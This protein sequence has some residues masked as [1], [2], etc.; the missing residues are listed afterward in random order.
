MEPK[1]QDLYPSFSISPD[2]KPEW[3]AVR[4]GMLVRLYA[5]NKNQIV[6]KAIVK[7]I[8]ALLAFGGYINDAE[9]RCQYLRLAAHWRCLAWVSNPN[10]YTIEPCSKAITCQ[11]NRG[12]S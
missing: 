1:Q 9:Q 10:S 7:H 3:I 5:V 2:E 4:T 11:F 8:N 12:L 6:A